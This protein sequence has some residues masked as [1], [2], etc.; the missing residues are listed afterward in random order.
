MQE[1]K[2]ILCLG[3]N[4]EDTDLRANKL[5]SNKGLSNFGLISKENVNNEISIGIYHTTLVDCTYQ[6]IQLLVPKFDLVYVFDQDYE[7]SIV[8]HRTLEIAEKIKDK[9]TVEF[10]NKQSLDN[11]NYWE[12]LVE[13]NSSFCIYP[14]IELMS[15]EKMT[16]LCCRSHVPVEDMENLNDW[17]TNKQYSNIRN[18]MLAGE[19]IVNCNACYNV[20]KIGIKSSRQSDTVEWATKLNLKSTDELKTI[21]SPVYYEIRASNVCNLQCRMCGPRWSNQIEK[22]YKDL[23][24]IPQKTEYK[25]TGFD[26][27]DFKNLQKLYVGGGEPT[28][29]IEFIKFLENLIEKDYTDFELQINTNATSINK[30][31]RDIIKHFPRTMFTVSID[32]YQDLNYYIRY[33][34]NWNEIVDN[35]QW[36]VDNNFKLT[37]N[38]TASVLNIGRLSEIFNFLD[39]KFPGNWLDC[40]YAKGPLTPF[41]YPYRD[42]ALKDLE[43]ITNQPYYKNNAVFTNNIDGLINYFKQQTTVDQNKLQK[44][45]DL[46]DKLDKSRNIKLEDYRPELEQW[47][48]DQTK[49]IKNI[50]AE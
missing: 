40:N 11:K 8:K 28:V 23:G 25:H 44:F 34:G 48:K 9:I 45:F 3:N 15:Q 41:A 16:T 36:I 7:E 46:N 39:E 31:F 49:Q 27:V 38:T 22:E 43:I 24:L 33:P 10:E 2:R 26:Y 21:K 35:V 20:E 30:K 14:F 1:S 50:N 6:D 29:Q 18:K 47:R 4:T 19:R 13:E 17:Q 12:K 42:Q 37:F 5:A 32:G